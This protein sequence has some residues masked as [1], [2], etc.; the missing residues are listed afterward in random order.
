M[1]FLVFWNLSFPKLN[2]MSEEIF[3]PQVIDCYHQHEYYEV[4]ADGPNDPE[5]LNLIAT[6]DPV[7]QLRLG[8]PHIRYFRIVPADIQH[9]ESRKVVYLPPG[10]IV[11]FSSGMRRKR[12]V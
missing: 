4:I 11:N 3:H 7:V 12:A 2:S 9:L 1:N 6:F 8:E 5:E 10:T